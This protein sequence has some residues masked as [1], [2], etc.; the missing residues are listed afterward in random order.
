MKICNNLFLFFDKTLLLMEGSIGR[1]AQYVNH[2]YDTP[3]QAVERGADDGGVAEILYPANT[4]FQS[5]S[6]SRHVPGLY[7]HGDG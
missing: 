5:L 6:G 7:L 3:N 1:T 4:I 2:E